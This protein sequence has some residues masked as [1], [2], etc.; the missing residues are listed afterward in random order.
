MPAQ[1]VTYELHV[2]ELNG[3][4][5]KGHVFDNGPGRNRAEVEGELMEGG[6][7][8]W[9]ERPVHNP[10]GEMTMQ[11]T[12]QGNAIRL[13]FKGYYG[14]GR[15]TNEGDGQL[16][17]STEQNVAN[18]KSDKDAISAVSGGQN[19]ERQSMAIPSQW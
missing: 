4:K 6:V 16:T 9:R 7:I 18:K 14:K 5:F 19:A 13:T 3:T 2:R 8:T 1:T 11:G 15:P 12:I 10:E 17:V